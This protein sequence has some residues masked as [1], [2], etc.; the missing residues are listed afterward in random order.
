MDVALEAAPNNPDLLYLKAQILRRL[1]RTAESQEFFAQALAYADQL[2]AATSRQ[3]AFE[4]C[5]ITGED[6]AVCS[7]RAAD[8]FGD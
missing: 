2:P 3:I 7:A 8:E 6:R 5:H 1:D 4:Q